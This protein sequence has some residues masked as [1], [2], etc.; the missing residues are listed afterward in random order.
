VSILIDESTRVIV[1]GISGRVARA[2]TFDML[3]YGT[4]VVAGVSTSGHAEKVEQ[5]PVFGY[6]KEAVA[7]TGATASLVFV[8][9]P[10]ASGAIDEALDAKVSLIVYPGDGLPI[11]DALRLRKRALAI[12]SVIVGPNSPGLI[13][14]RR[15]K[16]G[17]MPANCYT[18]GTLGVISK[19]GS[20]S[21]EVC[22]RLTA[23]GI[24]QSSVVGIG[25][26]PIKGLTALEALEMFHVDHDTSGVLFLGEIGGLVE[27]DLIDYSLRAD[28]KPVAAFIAGASAPAGRKMGHA[29]ALISGP[30]ETYEAKTNALAAAGIL[31]ARS[32]D[33][34]SPTVSRFLAQSALSV[35]VIRRSR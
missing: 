34:I 11:K 17:F 10:S 8:P 35:N 2:V 29:S 12:G 14:P 19:S 3:A 9:P 1:Q 27:Y 21:Y 4:Q 15:A 16:I 33:A 18:P 32:L 13:S 24:G 22:T 28:A 6:V 30:K 5:I 23:A 7:A 20:L 26:D 31:V 25:G